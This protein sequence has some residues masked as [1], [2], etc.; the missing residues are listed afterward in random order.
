M[1]GV[2]QVR[3]RIDSI[4]V[5][6]ACPDESTLIL[7]REGEG[8]TYLPIWIDQHQAQI[9]ADE[10]HGRPDSKGELDSFLADNGATDSGIGCTTV[11]L[12]GDAFFAKVL[13]SP[14][15]RPREIGCS[16]GVALALAVRAN[17]PILVDDALFD[18][19]GVDLQ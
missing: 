10:L 18:R 19:A 11:Y 13:L 16:I 1:F 14:H 2:T 15:I 12:K 3:C 17:A 6:E 4:R 9:L 8:N 7:K 5:A